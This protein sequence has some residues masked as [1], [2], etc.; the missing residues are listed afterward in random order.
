MSVLQRTSWCGNGRAN[1]L[2]TACR[3]SAVAAGAVLTIAATSRDAPAFG[4]VATHTRVVTAAAAE[5][6]C[7]GDCNSD[8]QV[9]VDEILTIVNMALGNSSTCPSG[10]TADTIPDITTILKAVNDALS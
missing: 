2:W 3:L 8:G 5:P 9:T 7:V 6:V 1:V 4:T 10:V